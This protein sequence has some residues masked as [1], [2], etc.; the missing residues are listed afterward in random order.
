MKNFLLLFVSLIVASSLFLTF[1]DR[2]SEYLKPYLSRYLESKIDNKKIDVEVEDLKI[3][4]DYIEFTAKINKL[5]RLNAY[6]DYNLLDKTVNLKYNLKSNGFKSKEFSFD[7]KIDINGTV[8]GVFTNLDVTG[9]G[10]FAF[11]SKL[12]YKFKVE[13]KLVK[14]IKIHIIKANLVKILK[15]VE[16]SAYAEGKIDVDVDIPVLDGNQTTGYANLVLNT[17]KLDEK[18]LKKNYNINLPENTT[19]T[20]TIDSIIVPNF[21]KFKTDIKSN[22][23][24]LNLRNAKYDLNK[25]DLFSNYHLLVPHL[26]KLNIVPNRKLQGEITIDGEI[27]SIDKKLHL[28]GETKSLD[29][30]ID[31][32]L[33]NKHLTSTI[34][35]VSVQKLMYTLDYPQI[36]K[37]YIVGNFDYNLATQHGEL[38]SKLNKAQLIPNELTDLVKQIRGVDLTKE[39]YT[40]TS[41]NAKLNKS[42]IDFDLNTKSKTVK[43]FIPSGQINKK[44]NT[45][46]ANYKLIIEDKDIEG[47]IKGDISKPKVTIDGSSFIKKH[48]LDRVTKEIDTKSLEDLGIGKQEVDAIKNMLGNLFK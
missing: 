12:K 5:T 48:I 47:K 21:I 34:K 22:L 17:T 46:N 41:F 11:E 39:R 18:L 32:V 26:S 27:K 3:D 31:F 4:Y 37:A 2:G 14:N 28:K 43:L 45:I 44:E 19:L 24:T 35:D 25:K 20:A 13:D 1:H 23:L 29:G 15:L 36:F 30:A 38:H 40:E 33:K 42:L 9:D 16:Q 7:N 10:S 8:K 6:G